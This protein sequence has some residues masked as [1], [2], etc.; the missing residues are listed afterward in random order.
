MSLPFFYWMVI[1]G[2]EL[3]EASMLDI[4]ASVDLEN[5][6]HITDERYL[7]VTMGPTVIRHNWGNFNTSSAKIQALAKGLAP[8]FFRIGGNEADILIFNRTT[9]VVNDIDKDWAQYSSSD[10]TDWYDEDLDYDTSFTESKDS[11]TNF[12]MTA[13]QWDQLNTFTKTVGWNLLFDL[14]VLL[15]KGQ[16]WDSSNALE[17]MAYSI[18]QN[19]TQNLNF[20]LGNEPNAFQHSI[21]YTLAPVQLGKDFLQLHYLLKQSSSFSRF[22]SHSLL[23]G[24][25][26]TRPTSD[27][28]KVIDYLRKYYMNGRQAKAADFVNPEILDLFPQQAARVKA[29]I[30][31]VGLEYKPLMLGETGSCWGGGAPHLSNRYAGGFLWLDKLGIA[32][33]M[34]HSVVMRQTFY[35]GNYG[36]IGTDLFPS[37]DYWLSLLYKILVGTRVL[38]VAT[39][40]KSGRVRVYAHCTALSRSHYPKGSVTVYVLNLHT[41][42]MQLT[43]NS[44]LSSKM[45]H[46]YWFTPHSHKGFSSEY[47][48]INGKKME[49]LD[50][51]IFPKVMPKITTDVK[52]TLPQ[53]SFGFIV[54]PEADAP[55]C[56]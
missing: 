39:D 14:N 55:V 53:T 22:F 13:R 7:S 4:S 38:H 10:D 18:R 54:I 51:V 25:D 45:K 50:D 27:H 56:L 24:P 37:P 1:I 34:G 8:A 31:E 28:A 16:E 3:L 11:W 52:I 12:T 2:V 32:A 44:V 36:L 49:L 19:Y 17:L 21:N 33:R 15:R 46:V 48:D 23:V 35:E 9:G 26:T 42:P 41:S 43:L 30:K 20:E 40:D 6:L 5:V 47:V 29:V